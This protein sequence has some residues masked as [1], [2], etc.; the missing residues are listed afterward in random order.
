ME[1]IINLKRIRE[2]YC[3]YPV[4]TQ[5]VLSSILMFQGFFYCHFPSV[6]RNACNFFFFFFR[7]NL[8]AVNSLSFPFSE[9]FFIFL[10]VPGRYFTVWGV[11]GKQFFSISTWKRSAPSSGLWFLVRSLLLFTLFYPIVKMSFFFCCFWDL[12]KN[13]S[14]GQKFNYMYLGVD[15]FGFNLLGFSQLLES[16]GLCVLPNSSHGSSFSAIISSSVFSANPLSPLLPRHQCQE[17]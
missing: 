14:N 17:G 9:N 11:L 6:Y 10:F 5:H 8:L 15:F 4:S 12:K 7:G 1:M 3:I 13:D 2:A 16:V